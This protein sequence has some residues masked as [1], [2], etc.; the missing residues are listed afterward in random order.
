MDL[1]SSTKAEDY[2]EKKVAELR[3]HVND[4][5]LNRQDRSMDDHKAL[6]DY[7]D[8]RCSCGAPRWG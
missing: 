5:I 6:Q 4:N 8:V 7:F 1:E 3:A 2:L